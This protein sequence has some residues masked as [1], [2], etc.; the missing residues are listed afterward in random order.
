MLIPIG[1]FG[2]GVGG[3]FAALQYGGNISRGKAVAESSSGNVFS[4]NRNGSLSSTQGQGVVMQNA[5]G[6]IIWQRNYYSTL[7]NDDDVTDLA[8]D[9]SEN[10]YVAGANNNGGAIRP[11]LVKYNNSGVLQWQKKF[12]STSSS[13]QGGGV[14]ID[15][16]N[17]V[18]LTGSLLSANTSKVIVKMDSAGT[19]AWTKQLTLVSP[20]ATTVDGSG[21]VYYIGFEGTYQVVFVKMDSSGTVIW[22]KKHSIGTFSS[23]FYGAIAVSS[24]GD[25]YGLFKDATGFSQIT[26]LDSTGAFV[27]ARRAPGGP[28]LGGSIWIDSAGNVVASFQNVVIKFDSSG[29]TIFQ[30]QIT[31]STGYSASGR[32]TLSNKFITATGEGLGG[33]NHTGITKTPADGSGIGTYGDWTLAAG[34]LTITSPTE[35]VSNGGYTVATVTASSATATASDGATSATITINNL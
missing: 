30:R 21:N 15:P 13:T 25:V 1:F 11:T 17:N 6:A 10:V 24:S 5:S 3:W 34:S 35:T 27:W 23:N 29:T 26:K 7:T 18:F 16:S 19:I 22:Q 2:G 9:S 12:G 8:L 32:M 31:N 20:A 33:G 4:A 14:Y 28:D